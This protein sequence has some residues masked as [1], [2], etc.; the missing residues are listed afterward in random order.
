MVHPPRRIPGCGSSPGHQDRRDSK[1]VSVLNSGRLQQRACCHGARTR[2]HP[3]AATR[4]H[5]DSRA[6]G[7]S[8]R[9]PAERSQRQARLASGGV[10]SGRFREQSC[11]SC[12]CSGCRPE[13]LYRTAQATRSAKPA[14]RADNIFQRRSAHRTDPQPGEAVHH[15]SGINQRGISKDSARRPRSGH[16]ASSHF[17]TLLTE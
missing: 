10:Y 2:T 13:P 7:R 3:C 6:R 9:N 8:S 4:S 15:C 17:S 14:L 11:V 16:Q 5:S 1:D 12:W